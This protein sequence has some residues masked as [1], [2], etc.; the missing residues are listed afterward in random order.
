[1]L[2]FIS[3]YFFV[4]I[5]SMS[6][7]IIILLIFVLFLKRNI[8]ENINLLKNLVDGF[9]E[10]AEQL[11]D[12]R[13]E[14]LSGRRNINEALNNIK[15]SQVDRD[16]KLSRIIEQHNAFY[17]KMKSYDT[18][19]KNNSAPV[20]L[21][22][23]EQKLLDTFRAKQQEERRP[24]RAGATDRRQRLLAKNAQEFGQQA[25][26]IERSPHRHHHPP[27]RQLHRG[28]HGHGACRRWP[29]SRRTHAGH[30]HR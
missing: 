8:I 11:I 16:E 6:T 29:V 24:P 30:R 17:E 27:V 5:W 21:S 7:T 28:T 9:S 4:T 2:E 12:F 23:A 15:A 3:T 26:G 1:M 10:S 18:L 22:D 14:F 13:E 19:L 25:Q 20:E